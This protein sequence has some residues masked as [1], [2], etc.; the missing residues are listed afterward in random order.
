MVMVIIGLVIILL[1]VLV[2]PFTFKIVEEQLEIFLFIMGIA[3]AL[4]SGVMNRELILAA[5]EHPIMIA[6][7]VLI[8]GALFHILREQ[9]EGFMQ[10]VFT[11][12]PVPAVVFL[13]VVVLGLLSSVITAII[14]SI[15]LVE[16]IFQLPMARKDKIVICVIACF[17]IGFGAALTPIG[18]PLATIAIAKLNEE[19]LY[20]FK[21][22]GKFIIPAIIVF[23]CLGAFYAARAQKAEKGMPSAELAITVEEE[24][25]EE[26]EQD[27][28]RGIIIRALKVYLFVMALTFLGE[29][30]YPLIDAYILKLDYRLL[31]WVNT[32]SA[33][34]DNATLTAAEI[35]PKMTT[36][37]IEAILMGLIISGG[38]LIP[39]NI[40]N[41]I[42]ASKLRI[43]STE[44]AKIGVPLGAA[45]MAIFYVILF[46]L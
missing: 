1:L 26:V 39:G 30:F 19:F 6:S 11:K 15:I 5:F 21:L 38:M 29:G 37:Q 34:L 10:K 23:G 32:V 25:G 13:V 9:F 36:M 24:D 22:L 2:L 46:V 14:A 12:V 45:V 27:T 42:S 33:V 20:L 3:A 4:I 40:P 43:T 41:I 16:I 18:E 8:A 35:S 31:Y 7:A 17:S 44:W 28:W